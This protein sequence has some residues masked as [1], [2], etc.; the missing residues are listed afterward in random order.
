MESIDLLV[1][2][3]RDVSIKVHLLSANQVTRHEFKSLAERIDKYTLYSEFEQ[4][5]QV[6][7]MKLA[8]VEG[9]IKEVSHRLRGWGK[10]PNW[11]QSLIL[12]AGGL[13]GVGAFAAWVFELTHNTATAQAFSTVL[14]H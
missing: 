5:K 6:V 8:N 10:V 4:Y 3:V 7:E 1:Q 11:V 2:L 12:A 14:H 13:G 9:R